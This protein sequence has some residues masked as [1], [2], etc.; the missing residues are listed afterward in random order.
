[1]VRTQGEDA[2]E[3]RVI[4]DVERHGW[5]LVGIED[6][7]EPPFVYSIGLYHTLGQPE[8]IILGLKDAST[9]GQIV[10]LIGDEMRKGTKFEDWFESEG[11]LEGYNC[12]FRQVAREHYPEYLGYALWYYRPEEFPVLQCIWPD[13]GGR[14][15]WQPGVSADIVN[16]QPILARPGDWRFHEGKN[17]MA[18]TTRPVLEDAL[19]VLYVSHDIDGDWQFLCGTTNRTEDGRLVCLKTVVELHP[20]VAELGDLPEGWVAERES[21]EHPWRRT[22]VARE[23]S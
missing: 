19:P 21:P 16:R 6:G 1:M 14:Y 22:P 3:Q 4:D 15:P 11:I 9:M 17:R 8:I 12:I 2:N 23:D 10:N 5:H 20:A 7:P 18:F 13:N